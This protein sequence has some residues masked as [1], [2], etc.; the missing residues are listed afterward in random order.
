MSEESDMKVRDR[1]VEE[2]AAM[3]FMAVAKILFWVRCFVITALTSGTCVLLG[4]LLDFA[5]AVLAILA[6]FGGLVGVTS[7]YVVHRITVGGDDVLPSDVELAKEE[8]LRIEAL[9]ER[10]RLEREESE[11][12]ERE[13]REEFRRS[14][15]CPKCHEHVIVK[16]IRMGAAVWRCTKCEASG[17]LT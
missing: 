4:T 13:D 12:R 6:V 9:A 15:Q 7:A 14:G 11:R 1:S 5:H 8:A 3:Q 2:L 10:E 17:V 16:E